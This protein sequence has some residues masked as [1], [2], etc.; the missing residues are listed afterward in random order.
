MTE[1]LAYLGLGTN[2]EDRLRN[3]ESALGLLAAGPRLRLS[4]CSRIY[5]T[6]P[7]GVA[8]QP[9]FLNC[10]VEIATSLDPDALL[11]LC[12]RVE[13]DLGRLPGPRWGPRLIDLDILLYGTEVVD[14]PHLE[15]PHPRLHIR[16][17]ALVPLAELTP[18]SL[19]PSMN[20]SIAELTRRAP[21]LEGVRPWD[22][23]NLA[24]GCTDC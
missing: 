3:L 9:P 13:E 18:D 16:A 14:L 8:D 23:V 5:Q 22:G 10:A 19:H 1:T 12:K 11:R 20:I 15:I 4:R 17:F 7:W 6:A 21:G 2:L 24:L